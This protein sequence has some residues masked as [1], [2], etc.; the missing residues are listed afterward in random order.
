MSSARK[1]SANTVGL[2]GVLC[3]DNEILLSKKDGKWTIR[4]PVDG[5]EMASDDSCLIQYL[6]PLLCG[7]GIE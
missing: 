1:T 2:L 6:Q 5:T 7:K 3:S 4:L